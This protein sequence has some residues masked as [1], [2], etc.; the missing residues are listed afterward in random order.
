MEMSTG[1]VW[2]CSLH[3]FGMIV[4]AYVVSSEQLETMPE[5]RGKV[6]SLSAKF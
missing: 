1:R 5:V 6:M 4:F 2:M 3:S